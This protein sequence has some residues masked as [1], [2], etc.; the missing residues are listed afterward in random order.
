MSPSRSAETAFGS[1]SPELF[2]K[3]D[4]VVD[5][6]TDGVPVVPLLEVRSAPAAGFSAAREKKE[7]S[8]HSVA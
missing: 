3:D 5:I 6:A 8:V 4:F 1:G 7:G 2:F